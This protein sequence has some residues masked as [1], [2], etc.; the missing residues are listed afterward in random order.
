[1]VCPKNTKMLSLSLFSLKHKIRN[2]C[3]AFSFDSLFVRQLIQE[4][5]EF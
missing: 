4:L 5:F 3:V 2:D 1:M